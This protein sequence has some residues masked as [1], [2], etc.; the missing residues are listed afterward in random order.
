MA[1]V[2]VSIV[3]GGLCA[4]SAW[5][6]TPGQAGTAGSAAKR[7][8]VCLVLSG[9]GARGAAHVGVIKVLEE[10]RV[11][12]DCVAGTSM[13]ALVGGA[14]ASGMSVPE[15]EQVT[16]DITVQKL[17]KERPPREELAMRRKADD[18]RNYLGPEIGTGADAAVLTRGVVT[19]VQLETVLRAL[20]RV[21]GHVKFDELPIPF[22]AVATDL[23]TGKPVVFSEGELANVMRASMSVPGAVAPAEYGGMTLVDGMLTSNLPVDAARAMGAVVV[24]AVNVGTPLLKR[25]QLT[26]IFGVANQMLSILTEQNVQA[27]IA[28]LKPTDILIS[29]ELGDYSTGDFDNLS[30]ITPLG[31]EAARKVSESL[32]P[33]SL[34]P[35][36]Y[37][38][39]RARQQKVPPPNLEAVAEIRFAPL[40]HVNPEVAQAVMQTQPDEPLSP[41]QLDADMRRLYGSGDFEHVNYRILEEPGKRVLVVDAVEK[42]W[43]PNYLRFGIGLSADSVGAARFNVLANHRMTWLN[44][45]GA[46]LRTDV[47]LGFNNRLRMEFYQPFDIRG[48]YFIAPR[49]DL[50]Q[51]ELDIYR[52]DDRV[53]TYQIGTRTAGLDFG[54]QFGPYAE[55]RLGVERGRVSPKLDTGPAFIADQERRHDQAGIRTLLH[56]DQLD[57]ASFP[58]AGWGADFELYN[59]LSDLGAV[60]PYH[61]WRVSGGA[62][63]SLG[64]NTARLNLTAGG[65]I[66]SDPL[67]GYDQFQWGG[68]LRQS[69]YAT[70]QLVGS[71]LQ[72]GQIVYYRR[73]VRGGLLDGAYGGIS[74]E[75]GRYG[76]PLVAGNTSGTLKSMALFVAVDSPVGPVY[77]GYGHAADGAGSFYF[78]LG[79]PQ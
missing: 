42:A 23:V 59:S 63:Y 56:L 11:P 7:P 25:E 49:I 27:S 3:T 44:S 1:A 5:A 37:A 68:F 50:R 74:L 60:D 62:V 61:K 22:R 43:G 17:F 24:I 69:G 28:S 32:A 30:K 70:G 36:E 67:P 40:K 54:V 19:G 15:M 78:S 55:L 2:A 58:R 79:L 33:L 26:S 77:L 76:T 14:F 52:G 57:S 20:S 31:E 39:L 34:P 47:Q 41:S 75:I 73:L 4:G 35:A 66:G 10:L 64:E 6:A 51:E 38:A 65:R 21:P 13:G 8:R 12:V 71:S 45:L 46:E 16:A 53:A 48:R 18:F 29:P 72:F 9:G